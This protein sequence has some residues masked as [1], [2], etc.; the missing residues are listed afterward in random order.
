MSYIPG[1]STLRILWVDA[2]H[3]LRIVASHPLRVVASHPLGVV[4]LD[5]TG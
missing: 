1:G 5:H 3:P 4:T 2:S